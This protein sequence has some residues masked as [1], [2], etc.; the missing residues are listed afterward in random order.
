[1]INTGIVPIPTS[2][3]MRWKACINAESNFRTWDSSSWFCNPDSLTA[4]K[5]LVLTCMVGH[6]EKD[7]LVLIHQGS[8]THC[9]SVRGW[10]THFLISL[11]PNGVR[12]WS[13]THNRLPF[14]VPSVC[15]QE[16]RVFTHHDSTHTSFKSA[17][18]REEL[19]WHSV[20]RMRLSTVRQMKP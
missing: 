6:C 10:H 15:D 19:G 4:D 20:A 1:M 5:P 16:S 3:S 12:V 9:V 14:K 13:N 11:L 8:C 2:Y 17:E 18:W 7:S